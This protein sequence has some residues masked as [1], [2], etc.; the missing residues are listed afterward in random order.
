MMHRGFGS[1]HSASDNFHVAEGS[2]PLLD[3]HEVV[4]LATF[5][6]FPAT[7][8]VEMAAYLRRRQVDRARPVPQQ[9]PTE[10]DGGEACGCRMVMAV[11]AM[12]LAI[13]AVLG[14]WPS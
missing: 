2:A 11:A 12:H 10:R 7:G 3:T 5:D 9:E 1:Q 13:H 14:S 6:M 8:H 4:R